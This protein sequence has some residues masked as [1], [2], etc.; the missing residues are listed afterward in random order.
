V[1]IFIKS[2]R[3]VIVCIFGRV[4]IEVGPQWLL[5]P[6][7]DQVAAAR[8]GAEHLRDSDAA[9]GLHGPGE[10]ARPAPPVLSHPSQ[11]ALF[12]AAPAVSGRALL[13]GRRRHCLRE[14]TA[15]GRCGIRGG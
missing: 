2:K 14:M 6:G 9:P 15:A 5:R 12:L 13:A 4:Q 3:A 10:E 7:G 8:R 11:G 1:P